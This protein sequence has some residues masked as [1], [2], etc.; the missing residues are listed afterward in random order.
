MTDI[1]ELK[2][3]AKDE[4]GISLEEILEKE[5]LTDLWIERCFM[6]KGKRRRCKHGRAGT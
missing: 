5:Y 2:K 6:Y 4:K 3:G 1:L